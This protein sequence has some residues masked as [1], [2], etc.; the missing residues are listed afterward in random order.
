VL[1]LLRRQY[2]VL[3]RMLV[4]LVPVIAVG[5]FFMPQESREY[6]T[7]FESSRENISARYK[8]FDFALD[9]WKENRVY[10]VGVG[11]RKQYDATNVAMLTLAESGILGL[12]ALLA[13]HVAFFRM[14]WRTQAAIPRD[15]A[16]YSLLAIGAALVTDKLLHGMV[17]HYWSR[18]PIMM[19]WASAGMAT[20]VYYRM[21]TQQKEDWS[22]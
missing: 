22:R 15:H 21:R 20:A 4:V 8:S 14:I 5:W 13:I 16:L 11:L 9:N 7:G 17:D 12:V 10:G 1:F 19:A 18:G 6:A 2:T 3:A